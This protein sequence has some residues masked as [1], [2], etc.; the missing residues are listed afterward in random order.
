MC[1]GAVRERQALE[2]H[3]MQMGVRAILKPFN[4]DELVV[5]IAES[6]TSLEA[7]FEHRKDMATT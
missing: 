4:I 2:S 7:T 3:L 1:T 5:V 6:L